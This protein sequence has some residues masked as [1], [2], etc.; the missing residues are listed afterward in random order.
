MY[1]KLLLQ[2]A[3]AVLVPTLGFAVPVQF[4]GF[5]SGSTTDDINASGGTF[6]ITSTSPIN[7]T[8][9]FRS[10]PTTTA[11]GWIQLYCIAAD[12]TRTTCSVATSRIR[13]NFRPDVFPASASEEFLYVADSATSR[14][15]SLRLTSAGKIAVY[16]SSNA[17]VATSAATLTAGTTYRIN[18]VAGTG[19][20]TPAYSVSIDGT[21]DANLNGTAAQLSSNMASLYLG[22]S[23][24]SNSQSVDFY[25]DDVM[26][27][28]ANAPGVGKVL[29]MAP[30]ANGSTFQ[31]TGADA[32]CAA[33]P[34]LCWSRMSEVPT[35]GDT[36]SARKSSASSQTALVAL[37]SAS[38]AGITGTVNAI[39]AYQSCREVSTVTSS[40]S[41]RIR[42]NST[43]S[44]SSSI[45]GTTSY[46]T[47]Q[48][49]L[50]V[51][52]GT[53]LAFT[54]SDLD[55]IE[56][57][58]VDTGATDQVRCSSMAL[59]VDVD[60]SVTPTPTPPPT[61]T[62]TPTPTPTPT[63]PPASGLLLL[64]AGK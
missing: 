63:P 50:S 59:F 41:I 5:E 64:G 15:M 53:G 19:A 20:G 11:L 21:V 2:I 22:K 60:N 16:N 14:K 27:D 26:I 1:R 35:D 51:D 42:S 54:L 29:R 17:L 30:E 28:D 13:F 8:Y 34:S 52:P 9:S 36:S 39:K 43:N 46:L 6:S 61:P 38:A 47:Q 25:I 10:N 24:N 58:A 31:F 32:T 33:T 40:T 37:V 56:L 23:V 4:T 57:G 18:V 55:Q 62:S 45:N 3:L 7:G 48:R 44:D 12:G 49:L